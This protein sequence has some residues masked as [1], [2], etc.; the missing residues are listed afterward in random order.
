MLGLANQGLTRVL[1]V[2]MQGWTLALAGHDFAAY[3]DQAGKT[4]TYVVP[5]LVH[6]MA[7]PHIAPG[8][9]PVAVVIVAT[10]AEVRRV[11]SMI[12]ACDTSQTILNGRDVLVTTAVDLCK[13][14]ESQRTNL[15]RATLFVIDDADK[16][17]SASQGVGN[18]LHRAR[19]DRQV[20]VFSSVWSLALDTFCQVHLN[21]DGYFMS[22]M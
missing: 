1:P 11:S 21:R 3:T 10:D 16:V 12:E 17:I 20:L 15:G 7:Q 8:D 9:G 13:S 18:I 19:A 2:Q 4:L 5:M 6:I 22:I 14:L